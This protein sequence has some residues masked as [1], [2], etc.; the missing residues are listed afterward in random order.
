MTCSDVS[1]TLLHDLLDNLGRL[2]KLRD[3]VSELGLFRGAEGIAGVLVLDC[4]LA[5]E[6][7][8]CRDHVRLLFHRQHCLLL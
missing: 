4:M 2:H 7:H 6:V 5:A 1:G 3:A 8:K